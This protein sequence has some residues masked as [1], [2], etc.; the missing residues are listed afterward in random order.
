MTRSRHFRAFACAATMAVGFGVAGCGSDDDYA[1]EPRPP[2]PITIA[3]SITDREVSV[4]PAEFG[5][6]PISLIVSNQTDAAQKVTLETDELG[7]SQGGIKQTTSPINPNGTAT[8][9]VDLREGT[10]KVSVDGAGVKAAA[11]E[12]GPE[13]ESSQDDLLLP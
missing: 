5:A 6:G 12:V 13:R 3:A 10:Y 9:K 2:A 7:G 8:I 11:L 4:S 1:N